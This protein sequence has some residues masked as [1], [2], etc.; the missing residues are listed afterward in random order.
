MECV[1]WHLFLFQ[2]K[3]GNKSFGIWSNLFKG[4]YRSDGYMILWIVQIADPL[5]SQ[6][7]FEFKTNFSCLKTTPVVSLLAVFINNSRTASSDLPPQIQLLPQAVCLMNTL[8]PESSA[9]LWLTKISIF[10]QPQSVFIKKDI[11][12]VHTH[13]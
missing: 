3:N 10:A 11:F 9:S 13:T 5:T 4:H 7:N 1:Y 2:N 8:H 12:G 6:R